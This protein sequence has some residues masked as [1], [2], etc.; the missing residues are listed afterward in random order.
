M[1][2][3][4]SERLVKAADKL[5]D[6][7]V[8]KA[9]ATRIVS[10]SS[11]FSVMDLAEIANNS[12]RSIDMVSNTYFKLGARMGLHWFLDQITNQP[13][14]NHWQALARASYREELDWQQRT[15]SAVVLNSFAA[16]S[17]D[18]DAQIDEWMDNQDLLLQ[19]WKQ[20]LS[21]F[22]TSQ[23]HDFAKFSVALRE[24]MLL[25]HNCDTSK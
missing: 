7:N 14:A 3:K 23:S 22:K 4:E 20:M 18:I 16:D 25:S 15:L 19:R 13:V 5:I 21:E 1:V 2:E 9:L 12:E 11:L 24:L 6:S 8:P 17:K 10:L